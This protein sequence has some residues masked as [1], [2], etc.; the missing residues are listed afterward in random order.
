[1]R[2]PAN[3]NGKFF[4]QSGA[5]SDG[6]LRPATGM[7]NAVTPPALARGYAVVSDDGGH[8]GFSDTSFGHEQQALLDYAY[9][10]TPE[11]ARVAKQLVASYYGKPAVHSYIMGCSNGGREAMMAVERNPLEF[12]GAVAGD[13][14]F[15]LTYSAVAEAWD[16]PR[17]EEVLDRVYPTLK[18]ISVDFAVM[19]P[20]SRDEAVR[21]AAIPMPLRWLDVGSWPALA[22][23]CPEDPLRGRAQLQAATF[24]R[25]FI[26]PEEIAELMLY[27]ASDAASS[28]T[29]GMYM[30]DGGMQYG[31]G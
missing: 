24:L 19:E 22:E 31:G 26:Q 17:R 14:G 11:V 4:F 12:D 2:L 1:M 3:W 27:L 15:R 18:R 25:R 6:I 29:G 20:A 8:E 5:G 23:I 28:C 13:P 16:T 30:I 9:N 7:I 10:S 21:V